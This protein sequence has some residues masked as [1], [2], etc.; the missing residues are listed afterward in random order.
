MLCQSL[1]T[2]ACLSD[3]LIQLAGNGAAKLS[4]V[5]QVSQWVPS[6]SFRHHTALLVIS[7]LVAIDEVYVAVIF[8]TNRW[9]G[10]S[11][12]HKDV[13]DSVGCES[14]RR[15]VLDLPEM[16]ITVR[17]A[18]HV[19]NMQ[20]CYTPEAQDCFAVPGHVRMS[21]CVMCHLHSCRTPGWPTAAL[22]SQRAGT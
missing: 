21:A 19:C 22:C 12:A 5:S 11:P 4:R 2:T 1:I 14:L 13:C 16:F 18:S 6:Q 15:L 3:D 10:L 7:G 20:S 8:L 9:S 17:L